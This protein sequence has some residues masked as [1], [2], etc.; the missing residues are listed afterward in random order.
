VFPFTMG[1]NIGT[2]ITALLAA[3]AISGDGQYFAL[4]VAL[5]HLLYN[6]I[7]VVVFLTVPIIK[8]LPIRCALALGDRVEQN[9]LWAFGYVFSVFFLLP[10][11]VFAGEYLFGTPEEEIRRATAAE[12]AKDAEAG[13]LD[14]G[15]II[16]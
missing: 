10:G 9:R 5:V 15:L 16:D 11:A 7:G 8:G 14:E 2:C 3:T 13:S 4:Q 1:A 12:A 6:V